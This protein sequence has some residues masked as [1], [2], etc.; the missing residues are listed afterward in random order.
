MSNKTILKKLLGFIPKMKRP[1][2]SKKPSAIPDDPVEHIF[3]AG[4]LEKMEVD[5]RLDVNIDVLR[6]VMAGN[7]DF[8]LREFSIGSDV[9]AAVAFIDGMVATAEVHKNI[10]Q[11]LMTNT[12]KSDC[13]FGGTFSFQHIQDSLLTIADVRVVDDYKQIFGGI[14]YGDALVLVDGHKKGLLVSVKGFSTRNISEPITE[15][16]VRGSREGFTESLRQNTA[17]VR[18]RLQTPNLILE[19]LTIGRISNTKVTIGY[20]RGL[21]NP[22]LLK[23]VKQRLSRIEIDGVME[24]G[25]IEELIEDN[26][27]SPFPQI[28]HTERPDRVAEALMAGRVAIFTDNTPFVLI[29]PGEFLSFLQTP[30]DYYERYFLA[31]FVRLIRYIAL[32]ASLLLPSFYIAIVTY[33]QE[34][35]P[36]PLLVSVAASREGVPFPALVEAFLMEFTFEA[37][38]EAG[39]RLPRPVG[40]AISIVGALVVGEAAVSAGIVSSL[41]VIIVAVTGIASFVNPAF[42]MAITMR[43]LRFPMMLLAGSLGLFGVMAGILAILV[44][45][46]SL[47]SFGVP[48][49]AP[50]TPYHKEGMKDVLIRAPWWAQQH[51]P[52]EI[53]KDNPYRMTP[54]QKPSPQKNKTGDRGDEKVNQQRGRPFR[55]AWQ[56]ERK[57]KMEFEDYGQDHRG[58]DRGKSADEQNEEQNKGDKKKRRQHRVHKKK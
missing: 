35:I 36:T 25:Y 42:N 14:L 39:L 13:G 44:H 10:L 20:V 19:N 56:E 6:A 22:G 46:C 2:A 53:S 26:P 21:V 37:L 34:M 12:Q 51:R 28:H 33:H 16:L 38:R 41:M 27:Y 17:M 32:A 57:K 58:G 5:G 4:E 30:E 40:Q 45:M 3:N 24:S 23:E 15:G 7:S 8:V 50:I 48:Y 54:A 31:S 47:R 18:R 55:T 29:V 11:P 9:R 49:L 1:V 52:E 43:V